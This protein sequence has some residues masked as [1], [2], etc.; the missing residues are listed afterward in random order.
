MMP[1]VLDVGLLVA[2]SAILVLWLLDNRASS[3]K[4]RESWERYQKEI[5]DAARKAEGRESF[6]MERLAEVR[7]G[8]G[9]TCPTHGTQLHCRA[10]LG[11]QGGKVSSEAR[12]KAVKR[13]VSN[14]KKAGRSK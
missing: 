2:V 1:S 11:S 7:K 4:L 3:I 10:C 9:V 13:N 8:V 14:K 12:V 5:S 6:L